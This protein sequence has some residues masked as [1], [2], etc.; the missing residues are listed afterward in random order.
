MFAVPVDNGSF[1]VVY[2]FKPPVITVSLAL[3]SEGTYCVNCT[4]LGYPNVTY[5]W[6]YSEDGG[7]LRNITDDA[8]LW[9]PPGSP[10]VWVCLDPC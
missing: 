2:H 5:S 3:D 10:E 6:T 8:S 1:P 4:A 7:D 9:S